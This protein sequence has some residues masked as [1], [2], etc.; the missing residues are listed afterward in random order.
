MRVAAG[1]SI[2]LAAVLP[3]VLVAGCPSSD[4]P[5]VEPI[6]ALTPEPNLVT[7]DHILVGVTHNRNPG[8]QRTPVQARALKDEILAKLQNGGDWDALK[9]EHSNDR[10]DQTKP[11]GGPYTMVN[12][13]VVGDPGAGRLR[14]R[15]MAAAFGDVSFKLK[16]GETGV[17]DHHTG[18]CPFGFH[19]I[20]RIK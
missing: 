9:R 16:V 3:I 1:L 15:D 12:D 17:A 20:K 19:I 13:G 18:R 5:G 14:R 11:A 6:E 2:C 4:P 7:V 10:P 8:L